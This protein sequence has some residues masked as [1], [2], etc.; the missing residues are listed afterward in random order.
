MYLSRQSSLS[1]LCEQFGQTCGMGKE[2]KE[3]RKK[4]IKKSLNK[5]NCQA[6]SPSFKDMCISTGTV[7]FQTGQPEQWAKA[8]L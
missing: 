8:S 5:L 3:Q 2:K 6:A 4:G 1:P 7:N